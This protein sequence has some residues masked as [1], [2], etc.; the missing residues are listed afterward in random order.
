MTLAEHIRIKIQPETEAKHS[1]LDT[2]DSDSKASFDNLDSTP[3]GNKAATEQ[4]KTEIK[5]SRIGLWDFYEE[6]EIGGARF[7]LAPLLQKP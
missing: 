4:P 2:M 5:Q 7:A 1:A 6:I 3:L